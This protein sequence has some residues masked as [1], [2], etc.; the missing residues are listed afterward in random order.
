MALNSAITAY[1]AKKSTVLSPSLGLVNFVIQIPS[2]AQEVRNSDGILEYITGPPSLVQAQVKQTKPPDTVE[3]KGVSR[4][5]FFLTGHLVNPS[6]ISVI[7][8]GA[9][10]TLT[11]SGA[12]IEGTF[13][14]LMTI[15]NPVVEATALYQAKGQAITGWF[16]VKQQARE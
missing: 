14:P 16:Q 4:E 10:A 12:T 11:D 9:I 5:R 3:P 6:T 13:F 15:K 7:P 8:D 2:V 1:S